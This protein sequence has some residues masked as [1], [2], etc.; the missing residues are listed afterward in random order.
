MFKKYQ[1]KLENNKELYKEYCERERERKLNNPEPE[2]EVY[3]REVPHIKMNVI[4]LA[5]ELKHY[6]GVVDCE[7][8]FSY[9]SDKLIVLH[10]NRISRGEVLDIAQD[11]VDSHDMEKPIDVYTKLVNIAD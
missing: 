8:E 10:N 9:S 5:E 7:I 1:E 2:Y 4:G 11:Y 6:Q 3:H